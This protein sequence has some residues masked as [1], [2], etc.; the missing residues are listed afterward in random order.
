MIRNYLWIFVVSC[1]EQL[2]LQLPCLLPR[3]ESC[4]SFLF[5]FLFFLSQFSLWIGRKNIGGCSSGSSGDLGCDDITVKSC[6]AYAVASPTLSICGHSLLLPGVDSPPLLE[7]RHRGVVVVSPCAIVL[8]RVAVQD[9]QS[10]VTAVRSRHRRCILPSS[11]LRCCHLL[12]RNHRD[13]AV[14]PATVPCCCSDSLETH[15]NGPD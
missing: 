10:A 8:R 6:S 3:S 1:D 11:L 2:N 5:P 14:R 13:V 9:R 12:A 4:N 7:K 15:P